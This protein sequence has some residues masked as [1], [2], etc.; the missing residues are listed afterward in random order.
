MSKSKEPIFKCPNDIKITMSKFTGEVMLDEEC[1][2]T[3]SVI[4]K[5]TGEIATSFF[6]A[7]NP[8]VIKVLEKTIKMYFK[9]IKKTLKSEFRKQEDEIKV[10]SEDL[11][12]ESKWNGQ[13][14]PEINKDPI[15][16]SNPLSNNSKEKADKVSTSKK[17]SKVKLAE[18]KDRKSTRKT[19]KDKV[20]KK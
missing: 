10:V 4:M 1:C 3:V 6:G 18:N 15:K 20:T 16:D 19:V 14:V 2:T 9:S 11:P 12:D 13:P 8:E 7:H 5:N 17:T